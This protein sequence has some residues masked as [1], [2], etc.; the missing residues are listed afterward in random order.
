MT[1]LNIYMQKFVP[2]EIVEDG[3]VRV[4]GG[5]AT[6]REPFC[7]VECGNEQLLRQLHKLL[8]EFGQL[9]E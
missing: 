8:D 1:C 9:Q 7:M 5:A 2:F 4:F 6:L 3:S